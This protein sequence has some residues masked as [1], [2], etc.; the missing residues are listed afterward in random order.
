MSSIEDKIEMEF[1]LT[2]D[3][4]EEKTVIGSDVVK[5]KAKLNSYPIG[6]RNKIPCGVLEP[7]EVGD[8]EIDLSKEMYEELLKRRGIGIAYA[9]VT[10]QLYLE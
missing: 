2:L 1:G 4:V 3:K 8:I 10:I 6:S 7:L 5:Y 9:M